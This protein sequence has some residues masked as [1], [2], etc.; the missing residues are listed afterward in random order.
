MQ[1]GYMFKVIQCEFIQSAKYEVWWTRVQSV[2]FLL[3]A[4]QACLGP[5]LSYTAIG[6]DSWGTSHDA[7]SSS[8]LLLLLSICMHSCAMNARY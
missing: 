4:G 6:L 8:L 5:G 7:P 3:Q 1:G 2:I